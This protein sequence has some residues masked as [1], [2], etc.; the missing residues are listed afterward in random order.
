MAVGI[1]K[2]LR[3]AETNVTKE[4][5]F[6]RVYNWERDSGTLMQWLEGARKEGHQRLAFNFGQEFGWV[7]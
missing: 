6:L 2:I 4:K 5:D 3:V 7:I 1:S